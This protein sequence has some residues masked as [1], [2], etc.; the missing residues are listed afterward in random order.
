MK[1][2]V[3]SDGR[4]VWVNGPFCMARFSST[5]WEIMEPAGMGVTDFVETCLVTSPA[6]DWEEFVGAVKK[7]HGVVVD[8]KF[9]PEFCN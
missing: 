2:E 9:R 5:G 3:S 1:V 4:T 8:K 6:L 7:H